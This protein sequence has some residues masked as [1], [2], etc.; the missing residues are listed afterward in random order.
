VNNL[1]VTFGGFPAPIL[2]VAMGATYPQITVQVPCEVTPGNSVPVVVTV[3]GGGTATVNI[4]ISTVSPGIFQQ[5]MSDGVSRAVAVRSDRSFADVGGVDIYDPANPVR[6]NEYVR[7]YLT[8][9]G[10]T[11][12]SIGT[13][14]IQNPNADLANVDAVVAGTVNAGLVNGP[15]LQVISARAAPDLIGVYEVQVAIPAG[16]PTGNNVGLYISIV[17]VGSST[18]VYAQNSVVPIGQ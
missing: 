6:L 7:F 14:D 2:R 13:D 8:G 9:L 10:A 1:T 3:N 15:I 11:T 12:P 5:V 18:A 4:P 16:A 17:P